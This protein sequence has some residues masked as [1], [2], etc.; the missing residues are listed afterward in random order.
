M[1]L[2]VHG[3]SVYYSDI[4]DE[5]VRSRK[6]RI[7]RGKGGHYVL[8][9]TDR[10]P[11]HRLLTDFQYPKVTFRDGNSLNCQRENLIPVSP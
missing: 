1:V 6:W 9:S 7:S 2:M 5:L 4:D 8:D 10:T 11:L 3:R